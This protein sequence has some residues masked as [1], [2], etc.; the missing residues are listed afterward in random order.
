MEQDEMYIYRKMLNLKYIH[1]VYFSECYSKP[2]NSAW[3]QWPQNVHWIPT[4]LAPFGRYETQIFFMWKLRWGLLS[5]QRENPCP[6]KSDTFHAGMMVHPFLKSGV[7]N[8]QQLLGF[9]NTWCLCIESSKGKVVKSKSETRSFI[10]LTQSEILNV[11]QKKK[12]SNQSN[13]SGI[14]VPSLKF[15]PGIKVMIKD[16]KKVLL[17]D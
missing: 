14:S 17:S 2:Q 8:I 5:L 13:S 16:F 1:V 10:H 12:K 4:S 15:G 9:L 6:T 3:F 11:Y 7:W